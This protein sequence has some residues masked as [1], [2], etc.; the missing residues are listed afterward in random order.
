MDNLLASQ[1]TNALLQASQHE[2]GKASEKLR[3]LAKEPE[4]IEQ[5]EEAARE[6]E[7]MFIAEMMK[8]MFAGVETNGPFGGGKGEEIFRGVRLQEYGKQMSQTGQLGIADHV[9][10]EM[11]R[12]QE[13]TNNE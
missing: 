8:P 2:T 11:I 10:Q 1:T 4:N 5:I 12:I 7:A 9:K 13:A 3:K 6:F